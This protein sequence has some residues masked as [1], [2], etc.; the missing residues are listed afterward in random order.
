M[1]MAR[2]KAVVSPVVEVVEQAP[3]GMTAE[4]KLHKQL[5]QWRATADATQEVLLERDGVPVR[6]RHE[7]PMTENI[8][9]GVFVE[10]VGWLWGKTPIL[11]GLGDGAWL[12]HLFVEIDTHIA[13]RTK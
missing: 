11:L 3:V 8:V 12:K 7:R 2:R 6:L 1:Q 4:Q 10:R 9:V 13:A 5:V